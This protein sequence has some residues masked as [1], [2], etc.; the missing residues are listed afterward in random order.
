MSVQPHITA[1]IGVPRGVFLRYPAGNQAGEAG[2]PI[3]QR[4]I[5]TA[6]L[7]SAYSVESPGTVVELPFR[8][9]R[10][11]IE[12]EQV[13]QGTSSG[14]RHPKGE[15]IGESLD[16]MVR[17]ARDYKAW[18]EGRLSQEESSSTPIHG[19]A[20]ALQLQVGRVDQLIETLDTSILDQYREVMNS[21][22]TLELRASGKFV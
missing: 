7:E 3:Q 5:L 22:A 2:K 4:A 11:P 20:G 14:P 8:W 17:Q 1:T 13:F 15:V 10:F 12:E 16:T 19:F 18:L 21:I 6:A 9:R